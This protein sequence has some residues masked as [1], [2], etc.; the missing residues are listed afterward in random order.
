MKKFYQNMLILIWAFVALPFITSCSNDNEEI[1][2]WEAN[3]VYLQRDNYT[4]LP[5]FVLTHTPLGVIGDV[6]QK[7]LLK[8][9]K[10]TSKDIHV[11]LSMICTEFDPKYISLSNSEVVIKANELVSDTVAVSIPDFS[12]MNDTKEATD[13]HFEVKIES[14]D[15]DNGALK[16]SKLQQSM[17]VTVNKGAYAFYKYGAPANS[18]FITNRID[19]TVTL[20]EGLTGLPKYVIDG[21]TYTNVSRNDGKKLEVMIDFG[22]LQTLVGIRT[23]HT[24]NFTPTEIEVFTSENGNDWKSLGVYERIASTTEPITFLAPIKTQYLKY[25][26]LSSKG[27]I[28]LSEFNIYTPKE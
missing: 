10:P 8:V 23:S 7:I 15:P 17:K 13:Y 5:N 2:E 27:Q 4:E 14:I 9:Q 20:G 28:N 3:Y 26:A 21:Q 12:F 24:Y 19:W 25:S 18:N 16:V 22:S 6:T 1:N 11:R